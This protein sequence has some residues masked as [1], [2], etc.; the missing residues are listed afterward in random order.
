[1]E[2]NYVEEVSSLFQARCGKII[3]A[4]EDYAQIA[5]WEK[6]DIPIEVVAV[7]I[8]LTSYQLE[9]VDTEIKEI[10]WEPSVNVRGSTRSARVAPPA[11]SGSSHAGRTGG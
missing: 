3:L 9:G 11:A 1:M 6:Q 5:E 8:D 4:P 7:T 2:M 10:L